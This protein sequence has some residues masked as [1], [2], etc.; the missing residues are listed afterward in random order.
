M[1]SDRVLRQTQQTYPY[2]CG[3]LFSS[4]IVLPISV[5]KPWWGL[6]L[7]NDHFVGLEEAKLQNNV[8]TTASNNS[9]TDIAEGNENSDVDDDQHQQQ[10]Q[11]RFS[12]S[13][14][15]TSSRS[16]EP[17]HQSL[18]GVKYPERLSQ[19]LS[20]DVNTIFSSTAQYFSQA[21]SIPHSNH[22]PPSLLSLSLILSRVYTA[23]ATVNHTQSFTELYSTNVQSLMTTAVI[24]KIGSQFRKLLH[25]RYTNRLHLL[26]GELGDNSTGFSG[27]ESFYNPHSTGSI[28]NSSA[29]DIRIYHISSTD[30][31]DENS[32]VGA[33]MTID[34][35]FAIKKGSLSD[36]KSLRK[37]TT[38]TTTDDK[39]WDK[40]STGTH[41]TGQV[42]DDVIIIPSR[43]LGILL[44]DDNKS[45]KQVVLCHLSLSTKIVSDADKDKVKGNNNNNNNIN[46]P[47]VDE[48][49]PVEMV[50]PRYIQPEEFV[51][52]GYRQTKLIGERLLVGCCRSWGVPLLVFNCGHVTLPWGHTNRHAYEVDPNLSN[53]F[54]SDD[55]T[56]QSEYEHSDYV[57]PPVFT[58][59][60]IDD[61]DHHHHHHLDSFPSSLTSNHLIGQSSMNLTRDQSS[62][63]GGNGG[64]GGININNH[65]ITS[66]YDEYDRTFY[67]PM[68]K[69]ERQPS[70]ERV[71]QKVG[72]LKSFISTHLTSQRDRKEVQHTTTQSD[73]SNNGIL[74]HYQPQLELF[75]PSTLTPAE[76]LC[77]PLVDY[78]DSTDIAVQSKALGPQV[79]GQFPKDFPHAVLATVAL[80]HTVPPLTNPV[81][82]PKPLL[83]NSNGAAAKSRLVPQNDFTTQ[84]QKYDL[85]MNLYP[86]DWLALAIVQISSRHDDL[87]LFYQFYQGQ[88]SFYLNDSLQSNEVGP[89]QCITP[90]HVL[91][92][93]S[94]LK[95]ASLRAI[96]ANPDRF[97][98]H[99]STYLPTPSQINEHCI[100]PNLIRSNNV[101]VSEH[102]T[103][104]SLRNS[105]NRQVNNIG[106]DDSIEYNES[107]WYD[108]HSP[109]SA[110][111]INHVRSTQSRLYKVQPH[112]TS[113]LI[114]STL[115]SLTRSTLEVLSPEGRNHSYPSASPSSIKQNNNSPNSSMN[116]SSSLGGRNN[117]YNN[118]NN[119]FDGNL[120]ATQSLSRDSNLA[121]W[122]NNGMR[123]VLSHFQPLSMDSVVRK[124]LRVGY[125]TDL[126]RQLPTLMDQFEQS[127]SSAAIRGGLVSGQLPNPQTA[128]ITERTE[129]NS[130]HKLILPSH[131]HALTPSQ[132]IHEFFPSTKPI[133]ED[134]SYNP[135]DD[136]YNNYTYLNGPVKTHTT[137][138]QTY[139]SKE[140]SK[141]KD[142][143]N[144]YNNNYN[145]NNN[146]NNN[147]NKDD[148]SNKK[149]DAIAAAAAAA[150]NLNKADPTQHLLSSLQRYQNRGIFAIPN[151]RRIT[152]PSTYSN[153]LL[154][155]IAPI[156][157]HYYDRIS[158]DHM[159]LQ[160]QSPLLSSF[161]S[162][163]SSNTHLNDD[164]VWCSLSSQLLLYHL[165]VTPVEGNSIDV[166]QPFITS[167]A[168]RFI[169]SSFSHHL[170]KQTR[171]M[172]R[173]SSSVGLTQQ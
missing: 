39:N 82:K 164:L 29:F 59:G 23:A 122:S 6:P 75:P 112:L 62:F 123:I 85:K 102:L 105:H 45:D 42:S 92:P 145:N 106:Q 70:P 11:Q 132:V 60:Q 158:N 173:M 97:K 95:L 119:H 134:Q 127:F 5:E 10:S 65:N 138:Q 58:D 24:A 142:H 90:Q 49:P 154:T 72:F 121:F 21:V 78:N 114:L 30:T 4:L 57:S 101:S 133:I 81:N 120:R 93:A 41:L 22:T 89:T 64:N 53:Q 162:H 160:L 171:Q 144:H 28:A 96:T 136:H 107:L 98:D 84:I 149:E 32:P 9:S 2:I 147:N 63:T 37:T 46:L 170:R 44:V 151:I 61:M 126:P 8:P 115:S 52:T 56:V 88:S 135:H 16:N 73:P 113:K 26:T 38:I 111:I 155:L 15:R 50:R 33:P 165:G 36:I 48:S 110:P 13:L 76:H 71:E 156:Y 169:Q 17:Q 3:C 74:Y 83:P 7:G 137:I 172:R 66:R 148:Y 27:A 159:S 117:D 34:Q 168:Q 167:I 143:D 91:P 1:C 125:P 108:F 25:S 100:Y 166:L 139:H 94:N 68:T 54:D 99:L 35:I 163:L 141:I 104:R 18:I 19:K 103:L 40:N 67:H 129:F 140:Q 12:S 77:A 80:Q 152:T 14:L 79:G 87:P 47:N 31:I 116:S 51:Y 55:E 69:K 109:L 131:N 161:L 20:D 150:F 124:C 118:N 157:C 86:V 130:I 153:W 128:T 146:N 43:D